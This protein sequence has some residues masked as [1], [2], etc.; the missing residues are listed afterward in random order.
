[1]SQILKAERASLTSLSV[2]APS[3]MKVRGLAALRSPKSGSL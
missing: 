2:Q 1:M 3:G